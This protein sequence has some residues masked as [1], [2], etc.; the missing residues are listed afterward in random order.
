M[1]IGGPHEV[2]PSH[3]A[4][5][6]GYMRRS[7]VGGLKSSRSSRRVC[8]GTVTLSGPGSSQ[9]SSSGAHLSVSASMAF[10]RS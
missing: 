9:A 6:T 1:S 7:T 4:S 5:L 10:H 3:E 8:E 2:L